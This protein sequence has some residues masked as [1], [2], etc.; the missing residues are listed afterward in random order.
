MLQSKKTSIPPSGRMPCWESSSLKPWPK[1]AAKNK[2]FATGSWCPPSLI[3][4]KVWFLILKVVIL[5]L[6]SNVLVKLPSQAVGSEL[7]DLV[8]EL[9]EVYSVKFVVVR[10]VLHQWSQTH[11]IVRRASSTSIS[12]SCLS[13]CLVINRS[14]AVSGTANVTLY[15]CIIRLVLHIFNTPWYTV[16]IPFPSNLGFGDLHE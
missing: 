7:E 2:C 11:L 14:I 6:G 10:Q 8:C 13:I 15:Y 4:L 1:R 3:I 16:F 5:E 9:H 12:R